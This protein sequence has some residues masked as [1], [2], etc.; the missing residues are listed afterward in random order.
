[1]L[2]AAGNG[3]LRTNTAHSVDPYASVSSAAYMHAFL[4]ALT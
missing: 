2:Q 1:M 4:F 3:V